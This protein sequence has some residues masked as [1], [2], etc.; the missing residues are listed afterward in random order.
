M[1]AL[2]GYQ[3]LPKFLQALGNVQAPAI[4][5]YDLG[6]MTFKLGTYTD[7]KHSN[8]TYTSLLAS[9][10]QLHLLTPLTDTTNAFLIF[11]HASSD[12]AEILCA[13]DPFTYIS[14]LSAMEYHG[15][16]DRF[17]KTLYATRPSAT[18]WRA[19][20]QAKMQKELATQFEA[21]CQS[22]LPIMSPLKI[23]RILKTSVHFQERTQLGAFKHIAG[24][25][26]RVATIGRVF[27]DMIREPKLCGG[28]QHVV[29][30][31]KKEAH[32]YLDFIVSEINTHGTPIDKVRAGYLLTEVC[33]LKHATISAW[34]SFAQRG[35]SRKLDPHSEYALQY[36]EIWQLS[37]NV[38]SIS[39][40]A[41]IDDS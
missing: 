18:A 10:L 33:K 2:Q 26:L 41:N 22:K 32:R 31:Y 6:A 1:Q 30:V 29:D 39:K 40:A 5:A 37:I 34:L 8:S 38:P 28:I 4:S 17:S 3:H 36:S 7:I 21:Y 16:T 24:R 14:H 23:D 11:R 13:I 25:S 19:Q 12:P 15:L 35:G 20:A 9:L 27:L